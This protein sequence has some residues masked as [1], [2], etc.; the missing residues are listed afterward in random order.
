MHALV[1]FI[2]VA[3]GIPVDGFE[4]L[5]RVQRRRKDKVLRAAAVV[6]VRQRFSA[7]DSAFGRA[8]YILF[9]ILQL[10]VAVEH[11]ISE[12][13]SRRQVRMIVQIDPARREAADGAERVDVV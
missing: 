3:E 2:D 10:A 13:L 8:E 1:R 4:K 12:F 7:A 9:R 6:D 5:F 11:L